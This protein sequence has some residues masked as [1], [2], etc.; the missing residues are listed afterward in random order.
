M[1]G[2]IPQGRYHVSEDQYRDLLHLDDVLN[3]FPRIPPERGPVSREDGG[4][5]SN[6]KLN[7]AIPFL[8]DLFLQPRMHLT[9][10]LMKGSHFVEVFDEEPGLAVALKV[11]SNLVAMVMISSNEGV[12]PK[13]I[14][15]SMAA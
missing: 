2:R 10:V 8:I 3:A 7:T 9:S 6:Q 12:S 13:N 14:G 15:P 5:R 1:P 4:L 11:V